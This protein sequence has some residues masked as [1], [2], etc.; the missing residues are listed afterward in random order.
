MT[1]LVSALAAIGVIPIL[2]SSAIFYQDTDYLKPLD[3]T[4]MAWIDIE[5]VLQCAGTLVNESFVLTSAS[6]F[7]KNA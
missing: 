2:H 5:G 4:S 6:C 1:S 7:R 3:F